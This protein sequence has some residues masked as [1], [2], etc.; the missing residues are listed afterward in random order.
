MSLTGSKPDDA[1]SIKTFTAAQKPYEFVKRLVASSPAER[2][3]LMDSQ[4]VTISPK[5]SSIDELICTLQ[6]IGFQNS[7]HDMLAP[8]QRPSSIKKT[9]NGQY[10][11]KYDM[12]GGIPDAVKQYF[13]IFKKH[14]VYVYIYGG[15]VRDKL[16]GKKHHDIDCLVE[17][18]ES[19]FIELLP[20]AKKVYGIPNKIV[21]QVTTDISFTIQKKIDFKQFFRDTILPMN[22]LVVD[23]WG[24]IL[25]PCD[26]LILLFAPDIKAQPQMNEKQLVAAYEKD[27]S[28]LIKLVTYASNLGKCWD[29]KHQAAIKAG[30]G[31]FTQMPFN[32]FAVCFRDLFVRGHAEIALFIL[33]YLGFLPTL[34]QAPTYQNKDLFNPNTIDFQLVQMQCQE[35]DNLKPTE[36]NDLHAM[37]VLGL[38]LIPLVAAQKKQTKTN[39]SIDRIMVTVIE[40]FFVQYPGEK[41]KASEQARKAQLQAALKIQWPQYEKQLSRWKMREAARMNKVYVPKYLAQQVT[42]EDAAQSPTLKS[43]PKNKKPKC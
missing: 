28:Q 9:K 19:T 23:F 35:W 38:F 17:C 24:R 20:E 18:D 10:I 14:K 27:W 36:K 3:T 33:Y 42:T 39:Q 29:E 22:K 41:D 37:M 13:N 21:Y 7:Q 16:L 11:T 5:I 6:K 8:K 30:C 12:P 43:K 2:R 32:R 40:Q 4:L 34:C 15:W 31:Q 1:A 26:G 25:D